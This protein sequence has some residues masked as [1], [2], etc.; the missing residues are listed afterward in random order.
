MGQDVNIIQFVNSD[1]QQRVGIVN[2]NEAADLTAVV[3]E[4][5]GTVQLAFKRN[6]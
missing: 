2:G 1:G 5:S 4:I 3:P 6:T